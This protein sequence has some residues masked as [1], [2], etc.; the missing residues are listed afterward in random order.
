MF[1]RRLCAAAAAVGLVGVAA[2]VSGALADATP[3]APAPLATG[4]PVLT[5]VPPKVG[6]I[7]V[8]IGP[9]IIGGKVIS[10]GVHVLMPG[11]SLPTLNWTPPPFTWPPAH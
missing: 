6:P 3:A 8:N 1:L 2:P 7:T 5:F 10:P 9:T 4:L 11:V